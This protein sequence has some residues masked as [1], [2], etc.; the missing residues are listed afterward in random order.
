MKKLTRLRN[1]NHKT[2]DFPIKKTKNTNQLDK[3]REIIEIDPDPVHMNMKE[4]DLTHSKVEKGQG[5]KIK[6]TRRKSKKKTKSIKKRNTETIHLILDLFHDNKFMKK[7]N[8]MTS[9]N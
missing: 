7:L 8:L 3:N 1:F 4:E 2:K 9:T 6:R 5:K